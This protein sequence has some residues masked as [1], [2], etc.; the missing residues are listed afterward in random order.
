MTDAAK[1]LVVFVRVH[2]SVR[3]CMLSVSH[4]RRPTTS[5]RRGCDA[6]ARDA[7]THYNNAGRRDNDDDDDDADL[8]AF[9]L[10]VGECVAIVRVFVFDMQPY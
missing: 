2:V 3:V 1:S 7:A 4:R 5:K 6:D 8:C 10:C 9:V